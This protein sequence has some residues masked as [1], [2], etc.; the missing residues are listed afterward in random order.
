[1]PWSARVLES[2]AR[3]NFFGVDPL[4][5]APAFLR[6]CIA[7]HRGAEDRARKSLTETKHVVAMTP[8]RY[9]QLV[10]AF[11]TQ[12]ARDESGLEKIQATARQIA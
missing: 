12:I 3:E 6:L 7:M 8:S 2:V 1:M 4:N 11:S 5:V 10:S 9:F